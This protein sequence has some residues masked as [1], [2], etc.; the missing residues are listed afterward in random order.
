M[1]RIRTVLGSL[2]LLVVSVLFALLAAEGVLRI[3]PGPLSENAQIRLH[4]ASQPREA[5]PSPHR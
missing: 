5:P 2:T 1:V 4:W 3:R